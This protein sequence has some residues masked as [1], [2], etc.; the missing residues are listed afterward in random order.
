MKAQRLKRGGRGGRP[1]EWGEGQAEG[2]MRAAGEW[3][4]QME[5]RL[6]LQGAWD[7]CLVWWGWDDHDL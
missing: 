6:P 5:A 4:A 2:K 3:H 7:L 1:T